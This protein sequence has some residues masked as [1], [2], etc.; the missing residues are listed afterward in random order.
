MS[1]VWDISPFAVHSNVI[2]GKAVKQYIPTTIYKEFGQLI[3]RG[4]PN[5]LF[6]GTIQDLTVILII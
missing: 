4:N 3:K 5:A 6:S 1:T 2:K